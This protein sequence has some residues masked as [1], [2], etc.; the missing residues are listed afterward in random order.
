[1]NCYSVIKIIMKMI[2]VKRLEHDT[3]KYVSSKKEWNKLLI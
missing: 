1:M 3:K 2:N